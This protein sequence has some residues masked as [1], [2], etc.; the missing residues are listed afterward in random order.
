[1]V[2]VWYLEDELMLLHIFSDLHLEFGLRQ[3]PETTADLIIA[4]GDI[5][6]GKRGLSWLREHFPGKRIL[7]VLGNHE[8]YRG[9]YPRLLTE[10]TEATQGTNVEILENRA[11]KIED[12]VFLGASLWTDLKLFGDV[13]QSSTDALGMNDYKL[14]N[15]LPNYS[16]LR[17]ADTRRIHLQTLKWFNQALQEHAGSRIVVVTHHA[18]SPSSV[19]PEF[20]T[21]RLTP[22]YAS[23]LTELVHASKALLWIHGHIHTAVN[24]QIGST[25]VLSN[26]G[27][28]PDEL[29]NGFNPAFL[30]DL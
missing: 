19:P 13:F 3:I 2:G 9:T 11:V 29:Q 4:A 28:Y 26:P 22:C 17:P 21:N 27:G 6:V 5:H 10:L 18:P 30:V 7:Y 25:R 14:I 15:T 24:Y 1:M 20:R 12:V 23:D 16:R 8:Y